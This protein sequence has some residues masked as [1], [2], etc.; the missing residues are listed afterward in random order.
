LLPAESV[1]SIAFS[2]DGTFL[3]AG[4]SEG[5]LIWRAR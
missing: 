1:H 3:V 2:P 5:A 4:T